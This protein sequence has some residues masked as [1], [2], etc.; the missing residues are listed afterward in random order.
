[1]ARRKNNKSESQWLLSPD[2]S[3]SESSI[4][5][6]CLLEERKTR[7]PPKSAARQKNAKASS[8]TKK[9]RRLDESPG[10]LEMFS[11]DTLSSSSD[12]ESSLS[13]RKHIAIGKKRKKESS[14]RKQKSKDAPLGGDSDDDSDSDEDEDGYSSLEDDG[15]NV[16]QLLTPKKENL[17]KRGPRRKAPS[18]ISHRGKQ[19][20]VPVMG[21]V[22]RD[23]QHVSSLK[24]DSLDD[25]DDDGDSV[26]IEQQSDLS[27]SLATDLS[28][29]EADDVNSTN[30]SISY[31]PRF[32]ADGS[33]KKP[34]HALNLQ[35][36]V[37]LLEQQAD[38][39]T[40]TVCAS[41]SRKGFL[42]ESKRLQVRSD[43]HSK[44]VISKV[45]QLLRSTKL[46]NAYNRAQDPL[47]EPMDRINREREKDLERT[48]NVLE[49]LA[50]QR[51]RLQEELKQETLR[52]DKLAAELA[53]AQADDD[54]HVHSLL[55]Q[56]NRATA[57]GIAGGA[58]QKAVPLQLRSAPKGTMA[59]LVLKIAKAHQ[60]HEH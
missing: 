40:S 17:S 24:E 23:R 4:L 8:N 47:A 34:M 30:D 2:E 18:S 10:L 41:L 59:R 43:K 11:P 7:T 27:K 51:E 50:Q 25:D 12:S 54:D 29:S 37:H 13:F 58:V 9:R 42:Q 49:K 22:R 32:V 60:H 19:K 55:S 39:A 16:A 15:K 52:Y 20:A 14:L 38:I 48:E 56:R 45:R 6:E 28:D 46:P 26:S 5:S 31:E 35:F 36:A 33:G 53:R 1:M 3:S 44:K 57:T 21:P